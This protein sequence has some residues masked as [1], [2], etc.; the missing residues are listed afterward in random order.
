MN[1][2]TKPPLPN[3]EQIISRE[4]MAAI[5]MAAEHDALLCRMFGLPDIES[6]RQWQKKQEEHAAL[7]DASNLV[8]WLAGAQSDNQKATEWL[9][10]NRASLTTD[11]LRSIVHA[12]MVHG[13]SEFMRERAN[14]RHA[15]T[16]GTDFHIQ[17]L[18]GEYRERGLSR[19]NAAPRIALEVGQ[20]EST[21][22][23]KL[24]AK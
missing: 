13:E 14:I 4:V 10:E 5:K 7:I 9:E 2:K 8:M 3:A 19:N 6:L 24:K 21:V 11:K 1:R 16:K 20:A 23:G 17:R 18:W 22:R 12:A 15:G